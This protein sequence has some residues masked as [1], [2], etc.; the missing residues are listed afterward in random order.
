M[1]K[2]CKFN[3]AFLVLFFMSTGA[4][5]AQIEHQKRFEIDYDWRYE[6]NEVVSND[7]RGLTLIQTNRETVGRTYKVKFTHLDKNLEEV[8]IDS[9]QIS[10]KMHLM[11]YHYLKDKMFVMFQDYPVKKRIEVLSLD[12]KTQIITHHESNQEVELTLSEFEMIGTT[13]LLGGYLD[14]RPVVYAFD[15]EK[16]RVKA[17]RGIYKNDSKLF[18]VRVNKDSVTFNVLVGEQN[19]VKDQTVVVNT[20][21]YEGNQIRDYSLVTKEDYSLLDGVSSSINDITQVI[22]GNY[23]YKSQTLPSG[24][25][26]NHVNRVGQQSIKYINYGELDSFLDYLKDSREVKVKAKAM[27]LKANGKEQRYKLLSLLRALEEVDGKLI[28]MAEYFKPGSSN[29]VA[30]PGINGTRQGNYTATSERDAFGNFVQ[31]PINDFDFTHGYALV[32]DEEGELLWD[33]SF[34]I[35]F[36]LEYSLDEH[37]QF[38]WVDESEHLVYVHYDDEELIGKILNDNPE[39]EVLISALSVLDD[40]DKRDELQSTVRITPWYGD[41]FLTHGIQTVRVKD[42][43]EASKKVFFINAIRINSN[44]ATKKID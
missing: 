3:I 44:G 12:Y 14:L 42:R 27:D 32:L 21:D 29:R 19:K 1:I 6:N 9:T 7:E 39:N 38:Q 28:F 30:S 10:S 26:I 41:L 34:T 17:L 18:E 11:G 5:I 36:N 23:G 20:Y 43:S 8:W 15:L 13:A 37:G 2:Q 35:D 22:V 16:D 25:Y 40:H 33:D 24:I 4:S 31:T